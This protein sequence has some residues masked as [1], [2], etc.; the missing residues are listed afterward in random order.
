MFLRQTLQQQQ[1]HHVAAARHC[2]SMFLWQG[3]AA[4]TAA[5]AIA[6][7][8]VTQPLYKIVSTPASSDSEQ[9]H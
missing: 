5:E 1:Q 7:A 4:A 2:S 3:T 9:Q 8:A 6:V